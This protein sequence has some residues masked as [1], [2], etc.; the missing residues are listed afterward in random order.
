MLARY[1]AMQRKGHMYA[2]FCVFAYLKAKYNSR[3]IFDPTYPRICHEKL[4]ADQDWEP[5]YGKVT[6]EI[7]PNTPT[8]CGRSVVLR[9]FVDS[10][11]S[12]NLVA[13]RS[14][15]GLIQMMNMVIVNVHSKAQGLFKGLKFG[16]EFEVAKA[17]MEAIGCSD[18]S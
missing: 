2:G 11:H 5:F 17:A 1:M 8:A 13:R 14:W 10:D 18:T 15:T 4:K 16:S 9:L 3:M 12:G 7:Q 6:E